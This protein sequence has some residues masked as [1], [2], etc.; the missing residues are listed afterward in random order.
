MQP[1]PNIDDGKW[2]ISTNGNGVNPV[3]SPDGRELFYATLSSVM[4]AQ[5]ETDPII[6]ARTPEEILPESEWVNSLNGRDWDIAP[7]GDFFVVVKNAG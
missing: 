2:L 3:W 7:D 4:V 5:I 1:F 6:R